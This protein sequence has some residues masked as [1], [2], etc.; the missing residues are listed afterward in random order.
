M[1]TIIELK[2]EG[3][4]SNRVYNAI[5]R[6]AAIDINYLCKYKSLDRICGRTI[7]TNEV[8]NLTVKDLFDI[9]G[10][11]RIAHWRSLGQKGLGELKGLI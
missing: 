1:K 7:D 8:V 4:I 2:N 6:H 10:E 11:E 3:K 5:L 9:L